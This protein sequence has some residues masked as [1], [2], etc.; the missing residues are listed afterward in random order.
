MLKTEHRVFNSNK[1][2]HTSGKKADIKLRIKLC[3]RSLNVITLQI[4]SS[5]WSRSYAGRMRAALDSWDLSH[6]A[7]VEEMF[8]VM[9]KVDFAPWLAELKSNT[10]V[11]REFNQV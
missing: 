4:P 2:K 8:S 3:I 11:R 6:F 1:I 7:S 5:V 9:Q 10:R